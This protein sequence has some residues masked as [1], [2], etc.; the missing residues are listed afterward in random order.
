[1]LIS[2]LDL[3]WT[4]SHN[5]VIVARRKGGSLV[6]VGSESGMSAY[7]TVRSKNLFDYVLPRCKF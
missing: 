3:Q 1:M 4:D 5:L 2:F 6:V 7:S